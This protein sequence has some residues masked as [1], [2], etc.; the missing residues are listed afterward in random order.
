MLTA[1][2]QPQK[3]D[4]AALFRRPRSSRSAEC[5]RVETWWALGI[6][7]AGH[8]DTLSGTLKATA[9]LL[10]SSPLPD[11]PQLHNADSMSYSQWIH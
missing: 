5:A 6:E 4:P 7:A 11:A 2:W 3:D 10:F 1:R 8:P 9:A